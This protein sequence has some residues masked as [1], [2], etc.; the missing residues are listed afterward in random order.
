MRAKSTSVLKPP[1]RRQTK[2]I[3]ANE[4][5]V[6]QRK[7]NRAAY[8]PTQKVSRIGMTPIG[9]TA[10]PDHNAV[11]PSVFCIHSGSSSDTEK[12]KPKANTRANVPA[13]KLR[14]RNKRR[15]EE[16]RV[17]KEWVGPCRYR[18]TPYN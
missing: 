15:S 5:A 10:R 9:A 3:T 13:A 2:P 12:N 17:G 8:L 6:S 4:R 11:Y 1:K 18:W 16:R 7:S 14:C